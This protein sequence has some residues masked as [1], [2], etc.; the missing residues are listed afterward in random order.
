MK[1]LATMLSLAI[2]FASFA[3]SSK[4]CTYSYIKEGSTLSWTAFK[5]PKKV[6]VKA[7]FSDF[8][9]KANNG[10]VSVDALLSAASFEVNSQSVDSGDKARDAKIAQFFFK[11]MLKGTKITGKVLKFKAGKV[12]VEL[13]M[14]GTTK[15]TT[16]NSKFDVAKGLMTFTGL[17]NVLDFAMKSNLAALT[18]ACF[19]K[20]EGVTW[21]DVGLELVAVIKNSCK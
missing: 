11:K 5:T 20:H 21:P 2:S 4:T 1:I 19:E 16:M 9:I 3:Q 14:N 12:D 13:T 18:K 6:G 10:A 7:K 15:V 8:N 17:I